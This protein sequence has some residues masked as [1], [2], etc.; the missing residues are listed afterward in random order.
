M[1]STISSSV[2]FS[3]VLASTFWKTFRDFLWNYLGQNKGPLASNN[4]W[5][6]LPTLQRINLIHILQLELQF[7]DPE[8]SFC[9]SR[10]G[11]GV[12]RDFVLPLHGLHLH[13]NCFCNLHMKPVALAFNGLDP[14]TSLGGMMAVTG[15][16][17]L[18]LSKND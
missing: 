3:T 16:G 6:L 12:Y 18:A 4:Q 15:F 17:F 2:S 9:S 5:P 13:A 7:L 8:L 11:R 10:A 14:A 1:E